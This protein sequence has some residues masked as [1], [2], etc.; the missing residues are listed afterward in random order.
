MRIKGITVFFIVYLCLFATRIFAG[1]GES[2]QFKGEAIRNLNTKCGFYLVPREN[3]T[4]GQPITT[5]L[6]LDELQEWAKTN[7]KPSDDYKI[8][9]V[10]VT[11]DR[12]L[13]K[14]FL[15]EVR[16][17][18]DENNID[19]PLDSIRRISDFLA[20]QRGIY[21][22]DHKKGTTEKISD[23][24]PNDPQLSGEAIEIIQRHPD[25]EVVVA[26]LPLFGIKKKKAI[27][28]ALVEIGK[29][30]LRFESKFAGTVKKAFAEPGNALRKMAQE[31]RYIFPMKEDYQRPTKDEINT[32]YRKLV[33]PGV[34]TF[35]VSLGMGQDMSVVLPITIVNAA[36]SALTSIYRTFLGN[37]WRRSSS[38][39]PSLWIKQ[40]MLGT[41]FTMDLYWAGAGKN[42][43]AIL[44][45]AGWTNLFAAKWASVI[46]NSVWRS[47]LH[48]VVSKWEEWRNKN[49]NS[50]GGNEQTRQTGASMEKFVSYFMTQFFI[51]SIIIENG[52]FKM[53]QGAEKGI[54]FTKGKVPEGDIMLMN[55]NI[56]HAVMLGV[57][58]AYFLAIKNPALLEPAARLVDKAEAVENKLYNKV[59]YD[60]SWRYIAPI[61]R[62]F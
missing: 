41:I 5:S 15:K 22:V 13:R 42:L 55:F 58:A 62:Q 9:A 19:L 12:K 57:G 46:F 40:M 23:L 32:T 21:L 38:F 44:S 1:D 26:G 56:G 16:A 10:G 47:P 49:Q 60:W 6:N 43:A 24:D 59:M 34:I 2:S 27:R 7:E 17:V 45:F 36:N 35:A 52:L 33:V 28:D 61:L 8:Y 39:F 50:V 54:Y 51:L 29:N 48:Y 18:L 14:E 25:Q 3:T 4:F 30:P 20:D 31:F 53:A 37:W 11:M